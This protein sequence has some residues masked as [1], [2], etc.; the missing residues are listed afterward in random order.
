MAQQAKDR[1]LTLT[2]ETVKPLQ[3]P[4]EG[5]AGTSLCAMQTNVGCMEETT[6]PQLPQ[7]PNA[8]WP[9]WPRRG[10]KGGR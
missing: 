6:S 8:P 2:Q 4:R 10:T 7:S 3:Q 9:R 5:Q 1:K